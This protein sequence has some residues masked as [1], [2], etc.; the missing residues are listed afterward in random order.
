MTFNNLETHPATQPN[1]GPQGRVQM[2]KRFVDS[3]INS[4]PERAGAAEDQ[5]GLVYLGN[6]HDAIPRLLI[7]DQGLRLE[8]RCVWQVMRISITD[9]GRP[10]SLLT[11]QQLAAQCGVDIKT[12]RRYLHALRANRWITHCARIHGRGTVWALHD[13]PLS[14]ADTAVLDPGY[15][16]FIHECSASN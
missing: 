14:L 2:L 8:E 10:A 7:L 16:P 15:T 4:L 6:V 11:Q 13:E 12:M 1:P 3:L 9:P 5:F